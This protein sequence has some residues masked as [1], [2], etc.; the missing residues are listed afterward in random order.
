V[1]FEQ[2]ESQLYEELQNIVG[3]S[4][5]LHTALDRALKLEIECF[6][7][8]LDPISSTTARLENLS[9][10]VASDTVSPHSSMVGFGGQADFHS[11]KAGYETA[12]VDRAGYET[13]SVDRAGY[14]KPSF[15]KPGYEPGA[16]CL[17]LDLAGVATLLRR[18]WAVIISMESAQLVFLT[19]NHQDCIQKSTGRLVFSWR[20]QG[21]GAHW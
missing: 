20:R 13:P 5:V 6:Q 19:K 10:S 2:L 14:K 4:G 3:E 12:S 16:Y 9:T 7:R 1:A 21:R 15:D 8:A 17:V 18:K 11:E